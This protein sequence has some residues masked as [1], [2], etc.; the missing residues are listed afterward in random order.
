MNGSA[1]TL[2]P[3][4]I[5]GARNERDASADLPEIDGGDQ[6]RE[7]VETGPHMPHVHHGSNSA[8]RP[9]LRCRRAVDAART[10]LPGLLALVLFASCFELG[11]RSIYEAYSDED[12]ERV[13]Q[14]IDRRTAPDAELCFLLG[15]SQRALRRYDRMLEAFADCQRLSSEYDELIENR[16]LSAYSHER[17]E[18]QDLLGA[19]LF[20]DAAELLPVVDPIG[21]RHDEYV[22]LKAYVFDSLRVNDRARENYRELID[23][24]SGDPDLWADRLVISHMR[25]SQD[26][27]ALAYVQ[28]LLQR[29][30]LELNYHL[31]RI[32]LFERLERHEDLIA[33]I[34]EAERKLEGRLEF[35][36]AV[37]VYYFN[38]RDYKTA[39]GYFRKVVDADPVNQLA[40]YRL[41]QCQFNLYDFLQA[42]RSFDNVQ[43]LVPDFLLTRSYYRIIALHLG[44]EA[45]YA[46]LFGERLLEFDVSDLGSTTIS[47]QDLDRLLKEMER[48]FYDEVARVASRGDDD[49]DPA[50]PPRGHAAAEA[51]RAPAESDSLAQV[52]PPDGPVAE[53]PAEGAAPL[54]PAAA[55]LAD[56]LAEARSDMPQPEETHEGVPPE[57]PDLPD[58]PEK[59][60][61]EPQNQPQSPAQG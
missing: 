33:A 47:D 16:V 12:Y 60:A 1:G 22:R 51:L 17:A 40:W 34:K 58:D 53:P 26:E 54:P 27:E 10:L 23:R 38:Q 56:T 39:S 59:P 20:A 61:D 21:Q 44:R 28:Q 3:A 14:A 30:P 35:S 46:R 24:G 19:G 45:D 55:A 48:P 32:Q 9:A 4:K 11:Y 43:R 6:P 15:D 49:G 52:S 18:L 42:Q 8:I 7:S 41:A 57:A 5:H 31:V 36:M 2:Q 50:L 13:V 25:D 37:G 29:H